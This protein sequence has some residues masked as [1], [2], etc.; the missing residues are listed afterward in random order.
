LRLVEAK[1]L[2]FDR[3]AITGE[4]EPIDASLA[5]LYGDHKVK[6]SDATNMAFMNSVVLFGSGKG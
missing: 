1:S 6:Y 3:S 2:R 4:I 5:L